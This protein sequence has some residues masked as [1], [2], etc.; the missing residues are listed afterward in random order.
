MQLAH[1]GRK[2]STYA[3]WRGHGAVPLDEGGWEPLGPTSEPFAD[4]YPVPRAMTAADI[5]DAIE[6]FRQAAERARAG[7]LRRPGDPCAPTA[8]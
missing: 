1:A 6:A 2:G 5:A 4:G 7:R 8:T 3:P